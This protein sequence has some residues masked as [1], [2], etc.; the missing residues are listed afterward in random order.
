MR[1][2]VESVGSGP[3]VVCTHGIGASRH[4]FDALI[5]E[6]RDSFTVIT[7]DLPGHGQSQS[8]EEAAA[9]DRDRVL[10]DIDDIVS[11]LDEPPIMLGHSLG[12][13][14]TLA[15]AATRRIPV[16]GYVILAT[17]P[18]F[19]N[20]EKRDGWNAMSRRNAHRFGVEPQVAEMNL[21]QDSVVME[22]LAE[23]TDRFELLVGDED[24]PQLQGGMSYLAKK[25][26]DAHL[27]VVSGGDHLMH[28]AVGAPATANAVRRISAYEA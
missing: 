9:Y 3:T 21:Q 27:T 22:N 14:L 7:W 19:R 20:A 10:E 13:Y 6:L 2:H 25:L 24:N 26:P 15:W 18:G 5:E 8:F 11:G 23:I 28:E 1:V 16:A 17:G 4:T 12:G